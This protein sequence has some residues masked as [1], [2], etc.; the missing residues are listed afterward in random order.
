MYVSIG[1]RGAIVFPY[2]VCVD[3]HED[4]CLF[5]VTTHI[6][7]DHIVDLDKS[8]I[9]CKHVIATP[10]TLDILKVMGYTIPTNKAVAL[11]YGQ[12]MNIDQDDWL[13]LSIAKA[14]HIPGSAQVVLDTK[15]AC[16]GYTGDFR[17]PGIRTEI[18]KDLDILVVDA[19]YGDP[20]YVRESEDAIMNEFVKLLKKLLTEGPVA[21]Y[22]Y[23]GKINDVMLKLRQWGIDAPYIL[24]SSQWNIYCVLNRYG[25]GTSDVFHQ[26][27][28][29]AEEIM[30]SGWYI[31]FALTSRYSF[32]RRRKGISHVLVTGRYGKTVARLGGSW[33]V[34]LSGHAD[35]NELVYYVDEAR[36]RLLIV[37]GYRSQYAHVFSSYVRN[38]L[39]IEAIVEPF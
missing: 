19:T 25:Y 27:S 24:S 36:P 31:E 37:D 33:V 13:R 14:D 26:G 7:A 5:R 20:S 1:R 21:I 29:E 32:L 9:Y 35:F 6:H 2:R 16:I 30:K 3:G 8:A 38:S 28:R 10:I 34:G 22:A 23:H 12:S 39:G 17:A 11:N 18:L 15:D 4:G